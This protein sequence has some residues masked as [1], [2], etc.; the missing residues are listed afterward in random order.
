MPTF[1]LQLDPNAPRT[2]DIW[3]Q[4]IQ[5]SYSIDSKFNQ[6]D[7]VQHLMSS[8]DIQKI[9]Q[10][11]SQFVLKHIFDKICSNMR[12]WERD[13]VSARRGLSG[14]LFKVGL[15]YFSGKQQ[16]AQSSFVDPVTK[17]VYYYYHSPEMMM[18]RLGDFAF[19]IRDYKYAQGIYDMLRK[20]FDKQG[21]YLGGVL[22]MLSVS[23]L[24]QGLSS[25]CRRKQY[26]EQAIGLYEPLKP[27]LA[28]RASMWYTDLLKDLK[29]YREAAQHLIKYSADDSDYK[30]AL[31]LEQAAFCFL[32]CK[33]PKHRKYAQ[34][35]V[36]AGHRYSKA[37][38]LDYYLRNY[39]ASKTI[40]E[41]SQWTL[42]EDHLHFSLGKFQSQKGDLESGIDYFI[43]LLR[44]SRQAPHIQRQ[45]LSE[46][47]Y[48]YQNYSKTA[49]VD[50]LSE[51]LHIPVI[52][53]DSLQVLTGL[54]ESETDEKFLEMEQE[55]LKELKH[56]PMETKLSCAV[57]ETTRVVFVA[58]NDL[59]VPIPI[60]N[61][62]LELLFD[63]QPLLIEYKTEMAVSDQVQIQTLLD[64]SLDAG[65]QKTITIQMHPKQKGT[66]KIL[67]VR[68]LLCGIIP[69]LKKFEKQIDL[70]ITPPMPVLD[71][72]LHGVPE[73]MVAG[74]VVQAVLEINNK[75]SAGL[76]GLVVQHSH[77]TFVLFCSPDVSDQYMTQQPDNKIQFDNQIR[78]QRFTKLELPEGDKDL[79]PSTLTTV[80]P[81]WIRA[82]RIGKHQIKFVFLYQSEETTTW[83]TLRYSVQVQVNPTLRMNSFART[84]MT[85][86]NEFIFGIELENLHLKPL[87]VTQ[88][89]CFSPLWTMSS[90]EE[91]PCVLGPG[92]IKY[93]YFRL[94]RISAPPNPSQTPEFETAF[95][96]ESF[97]KQDQK[98]HSVKPIDL[99]VSSLGQVHLFILAHPRLL[100]ILLQD[101]CSI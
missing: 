12:E 31:F 97:I 15:K 84:S 98:R 63:G 39:S 66:L 23:L 40:Y 55:L 69:I 70:T 76:R 57:G 95:M 52:H 33:I 46:F 14:R 1:V 91:D 28:I 60:N 99:L 77:P 53:H 78:P 101:A 64:V 35:L 86:L 89:T 75:G 41:D 9:D 18:R 65:E 96:I 16:P 81:V 43:R 73:S 24:M 21:R 6:R 8:Q 68:Y 58:H 85:H 51:L 61:V 71:L 87:S 2:V 29:Y 30:C 32:M 38:Q 20:D 48:L 17:Q 5:E 49:N 45:Y 13:I 100:S 34:H 42:I 93:L 27:L 83:R 4:A 72:Q 25:D 74:Q 22:E 44:K 7:A 80:L 11:I 62:T 56:K 36:L 26:M 79:L 54:K 82:S 59:S 90:I 88:L 94:S 37:G 47:L 10:M 92:E 3:T 50:H 67:G 19:M